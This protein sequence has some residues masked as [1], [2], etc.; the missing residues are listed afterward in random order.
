V[1]R[2][3]RLS[4]VWALGLID[5]CGL[6][7]PVSPPV[8]KP[9]F[10]DVAREAGLTGVTVSG[11]RE[12]RSILE[13]NTGG[14][15]ILDYDGNGLLDVF[16]VSGMPPKDRAVEPDDARPML[17]ENAGGWHFESVG[18][19]AGVSKRTW[20]MGATAVDYDADGWTDLYLT[21][22]GS[23]RLYR[24][25][26][27]KAFDDVGSQASVDLDSWS[28]GAAFGDYDND[29]DLDVYVA[30]YLQ[31]DVDAA[32][33][34]RCSWRGVSVFCGPTGLPA[35]PDVYLQNGGPDG[36]W[37]FSDAT[38]EA[39]LT[40]EAYYGF[41]AL[42]SDLD[43]DGDLDIYVANDTD[44]NLYFRNDGGH[45]AEISMLNATALSENG[46]EQGG[47]GLA[48][49]DYDRDGDIDLFV[50]NFSHDNNTLY[51]N[52]GNGFFTDRSYAARLGEAS[53]VNLGWGTGFLD[54]DN[55]GDEDL[56]VANGHVYPAVDEHELTTQYSQLN[57]LFENDGAGVFTDVSAK[58]GPGLK[59]RKSSRGTATADLDNDGDLDI[60]VVN[61]DD[62]PTLL[63]NDAER[64]NN[65]LSIELQG[66]AWN[67]QAV[68][69][70][71]TVTSD[72]HVQTKEARVGTGYLSQDSARM[73]FGLGKARTAERISVRWP[74]GR[75]DVVEN[76]MSNRLVRLTQNQVGSPLDVLSV[77]Y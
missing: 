19:S 40:S 61:I 2:L 4:A 26:G 8:A 17:Y 75:N 60:V 52:D 38:I 44:P 76:T 71:V 34:R 25:D 10:V 58:A 69:A 43:D 23:N 39:G 54:H 20:G 15:A 56:F 9:Q 66:G 72:G 3:Q 1:N 11:S 63:R 6:S 32:E 18:K 45:F 28:T 35:A 14:V 68:G 29:G 73:H 49:S 53:L 5:A 7:Q 36:M 42:A 74:D 48:A 47:M 21:N 33:G 37:S 27:Q 50:T 12:K 30:N 16:V 13:C 67:T 51:M 46:R 31:F 65:W 70:R 41:A 55:D 59:I 57:Q 77:G 62:T 24:N 22:Q 64:V